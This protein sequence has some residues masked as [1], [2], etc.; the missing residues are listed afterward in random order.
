MPHPRWERV[1]GKITLSL[2]HSLPSPPRPLCRAWYFAQDN[3][4]C[5]QYAKLVHNVY[6]W[7]QI[8]SSSLL[9]LSPMSTLLSPLTCCQEYLL[10]ILNSVTSLRLRTAQISSQNF[11]IY[12]TIPVC[13]LPP[14]VLHAYYGHIG[15]ISVFCMLFAEC[16]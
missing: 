16:Y 4:C 3:C 1:C 11:I 2:S 5:M 8:F 7:V 13:I 14:A 6:C 10:I 12:N 9:D 15:L